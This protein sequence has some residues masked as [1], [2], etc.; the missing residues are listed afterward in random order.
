[1]GVLD[2]LRVRTDNARLSRSFVEDDAQRDAAVS[3]ETL[4][5][6]SL[7]WRD[8]KEVQEHPDVVNEKAQAGL[9]KAE[10]AALVWD[11]KIVWGIYAW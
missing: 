11:K 2:N 9:K 7:E 10:A 4:D 6:N 1:M 5:P 8:E 3:S